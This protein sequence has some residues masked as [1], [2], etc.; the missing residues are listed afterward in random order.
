MVWYYYIALALILSQLL[1]VI[2]TYR[3][4]RYAL[5]KYKKDRSG[6][7]P[8]TVLIIPCKG[9]DLDFPKN[10]TSFFNLDYENYLLWFVVADESDPAYDE[11]CKLKDQLTQNSKAQD[12][13]IFVAG[14]GQTCSQKIHNLL[15]CYE[16]IGDD[17]EI[18]AFADSDICINSDWLS[19]IVYPLRQAKNGVASGYRWFIPKKNNPA[20]LALSALNAKVAQLLGNTHFN[21]AWGGSMAIRLDVFRRLGLDKL[22]PNAL[23]DDLSLSYA[24]KKAGMKVAFVPACLVASYESTTWGRLFEFCRRQFLITRV[25]APAAWWFG[26]F[27]SLYS[28]LGLWGTA[29][30]AVY[31]AGIAENLLLLTAVPILFFAGQASRAILRQRMIS[32]LLEKDF[33]KM[34]AA[35]AADIFLFWVWSLL[36]LLFIVSSAFGRTIQWRGIRYKLYG[37]FAVHRV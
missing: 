23:S 11:L 32:K 1:F 25:S 14:K 20:S 15:Y 12:V 22:W 36:L 26:L 16:R 37:P 35:C 17:V 3:N 5:K 27:S 9:W 33:P 18:M 7:Q 31:A 2:Q 8:R 34:K 4:Y 29:G 19:H 24:V 6:Y 30:L 21:Q 13:Q 10:I 28:V